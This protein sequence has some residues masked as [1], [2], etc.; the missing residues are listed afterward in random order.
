[1]PG[2]SGPACE[3]CSAARSRWRCLA[4]ANGRGARRIPPPF[5]HCRSRISPRSS[6]RRAPRSLSRRSMRR[7][8]CTIFSRPRPPS[9]CSDWWRWARSPRRCCTDRRWRASV[10]SPPSPP[11][12]W[13][14]REKPDFWALYLYLAVVTAAAFGLARIRL[15]RW[16]A[17]TTIV[18]ALLWTLPCLKFDPP[19]VGP[20][21][22]H[23]MSGF[24]L[25]AL[26]VVCG[27]LFGPPADEGRIEPISSGSLAAYLL[28][29]T[30]IVLASSHAD[31]ALIVFAILVAAT[32]LVAWR[33]P[34]ATGAIAFAA[35]IRLRRLRRMGGARQSGYAGAAGRTAAGHRPCCHRQLGFVASD[36]GRDFRR[37]IRRRWIFWRRAARRAPSS[38]WCGRRAGYLHRW[39]FDR[40]LR[41]HRASRSLD[42]VCDSGGH[43]GGRLCRGD[44]NSDQARQSAGPCD[45]DCA[46]CYRHARR[47]GAGTDLCARKG[48]AHDRA[49]ADVDGNS[50]DFDAA[51]DPVPARAVRHSRRHRGAAHRLRTAH[52]RRCGRHYADLQLAVVGLR[53]SGAVVLDRKPLPAATRRRRAVARGGSRGDPVH[54]AARVHGNPPCRER[55]RCLPRHRRPHRDRAA[56]LRRSC[57]GDWP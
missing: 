57:H 53:R 4:P 10:S 33:A 12:F 5:R 22:F 17:V 42:T 31:A 3:P 30:M 37:R 28:G 25:A 32:L 50:L 6:P 16:L 15:W 56:G 48:L 9:S 26:L 2:C 21:A 41:P 45:L 13:F 52:R 35:G 27:F 36:H 55:R 44:R 39:R 38:R 34:A 23:V 8:R 49:R 40:A 51:A 20:Y 46:V 47:A 1:M 19:V 14:L 18:F 54:G 7:M 43:A 24:V 11:P 29:A